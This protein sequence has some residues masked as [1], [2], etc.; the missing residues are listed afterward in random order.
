MP[1]TFVSQTLMIHIPYIDP[2]PT[3]SRFLS[4]EGNGLNFTPGLLTSL[5]ANDGINPFEH[6]FQQGPPTGNAQFQAPP[7]LQ[8]SVRSQPT[9][10]TGI[11]GPSGTGMDSGA[12]SA[13]AVVD[14]NSTANGM[15]S[16]SIHTNNMAT[17]T[18][19]ETSSSND[20]VSARSAPSGR[21]RR[22]RQSTTS[23]EPESPVSRGRRRTGDTKNMT[24]DEKRAL[25]LERN[26]IAA[27]RCRQKRKQWIT[28]LES[29]AAEVQSTNEKL[30]ARVTALKE[31][32][33]TL[34]KTLLAEHKDA[35][36][37]SV[38]SYIATLG[39]PNDIL[40]K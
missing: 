22:T 30:N 20:P 7:Q 39:G 31:E 23:L 32:L 35:S 13:P 37:D 18:R 25:L 19:S 4:E 9:I 16:L 33:A 17:D 12:I 26:R 28:D 29:K 10:Q 38:R 3:P 6:S 2:V 14:P 15:N 11:Y 1:R 40:S 8:H 27:S 5:A 34:R 36:L 24:A 21:S